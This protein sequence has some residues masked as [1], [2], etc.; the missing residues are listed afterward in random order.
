MVVVA[1]G[2]G[3]VVSR[4]SIFAPLI[5]RPD[6]TLMDL[7]MPELGGVERHGRFAKEIP[8]R[9]SNRSYRAG[10]RASIVHLQAL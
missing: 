7:R 4:P 9:A 2:T 8:G 1:E 10:V 3:E 6:V 5:H